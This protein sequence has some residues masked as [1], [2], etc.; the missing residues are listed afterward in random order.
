MDRLV[1]VV[2]PVYNTPHLVQKFW[3]AF[4]HKEELEFIFVDNGSELPTCTALRQ[5]REA[6]PQVHV[7]RNAN[8]L[9]FGPANNI[10]AE[11]AA[12][13]VLVFTQ[14]D[15]VIGGEL[16]S[17]CQ[18]VKEDVLYGVRML[19]GDTG[20]NNFGGR[21]IPYLEGFFLAS[22]RSTWGKIGGFD[23]IYY[24]ADFEDI[25]LSFTAT[26]KGIRLQMLVG[27]KAEHNHPG[28]AGWAQRSESREV[29]TRRNREL[30]RQKW[31]LA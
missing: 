10:G 16:H 13:D 4:T 27:V 21:V 24:P 20:W 6:H 1:S 3:D 17:V 5:L 15:V 23:P 14:L 30:F 25:D 8:N 19:A 12:G 22:T 2:V 9:G 7:V 26:K 29:V 28:T 31:S 18:H 11:H